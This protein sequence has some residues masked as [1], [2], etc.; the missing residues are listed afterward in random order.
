MC[1][2]QYVTQ[3]ASVVSLRTENYGRTREARL[4]VWKSGGTHFA[5]RAHA[6]LLFQ[7]RIQTSTLVSR[8]SSS[9]LGDTRFNKTAQIDQLS[10]RCEQ[11]KTRLVQLHLLLLT[12]AGLTTLA[13]H[14]CSGVNAFLARHR[15]RLHVHV[16]LFTLNCLFTVF[17][18]QSVNEEGRKSKMLVCLRFRM[19]VNRKYL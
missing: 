13:I 19:G 5:P 2:T 15:A 3:V 8:I 12:I 1:I 16:V 14:D 4:R 6:Y 17:G 7:W 18:P 11:D 9:P 10:V